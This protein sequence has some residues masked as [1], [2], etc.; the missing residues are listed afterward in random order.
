MSPSREHD[1]AVGAAP[2][3]DPI[4]VL[5]EKRQDLARAEE[6]LREAQAVMDVDAEVLARQRL[7]VLRDQLARLEPAAQAVRDR[8]GKQEAERWLAEHA[9]RLG[10]VGE[11]I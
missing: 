8:Q 1:D 4:K 9:R 3:R 10:G 6:K 5:E 2:E 7:A 11:Q